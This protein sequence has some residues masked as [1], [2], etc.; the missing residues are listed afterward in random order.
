MCCFLMSSHGYGGVWGMDVTWKNILAVI[1]PILATSVAAIADNALKWRHEVEQKQY[2]RQ[3]KILDR[4]MEIPDR[5]QR[6]TVANFYLKS[7]TFEGE[8]C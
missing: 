5:K 7:G 2:D 1:A 8:V 6:F 3:T 4:V